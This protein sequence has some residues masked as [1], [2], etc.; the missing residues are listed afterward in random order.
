[1]LL[2]TSDPGHYLI[3]CSCSPQLLGNEFS[4]WVLFRRQEACLFPLCGIRRPTVA[5][6]QGPE[7]EDLEALLGLLTPRKHFYRSS[8]SFWL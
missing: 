6:P 7:S 3:S 4:C 2:P 5:G 1:M 8:D